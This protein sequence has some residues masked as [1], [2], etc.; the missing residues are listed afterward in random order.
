[1]GS[2][3]QYLALGDSYTIGEAVPTEENFPYR[4][5]SLLKKSSVEMASPEI[6]ATTGWTTGELL[7]AL[8]QSPPKQKQYDLVSLLIGVNNQYRGQS[9]E[10]YREEFSQLLQMAI[11]WAGDYRRVIVLSIPDYGYTPA[12]AHK[13]SAA[14]AGTNAFNR[15]NFAISQQN[16]VQYVDIT[17]DS[18]LG[19]HDP[20]MLAADRLH[21]S[22][23]MYRRWAEKLVPIVKHIFDAP[24]F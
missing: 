3:K 16:K 4:L 20:D 24:T 21:P 22:G 18:R 9:E 12:E 23:K 19:L 15:I 10:V 7:Q 2:V 17:P 1:M 11:A 13:S 8:D 14:T 5:A 6:I